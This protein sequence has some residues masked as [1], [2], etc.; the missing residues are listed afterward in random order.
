M[1]TVL[2]SVIPTAVI[3]QKLVV[4]TSIAYASFSALWWWEIKWFIFF[5]SRCK[6]EEAE[7]EKKEKQQQMRQFDWKATSELATNPS[8]PVS[9]RVDFSQFSRV[10][11]IDGNQVEMSKVTSTTISAAK[12][13]AERASLVCSCI[14]QGNSRG[15]PCYNPSCQHFIS[16]SNSFYSIQREASEQVP[17]HENG[18]GVLLP[19][20]SNVSFSSYSVYNQ[21]KE[22][23]GNSPHRSPKRIDCRDEN[24]EKDHDKGSLSAVERARQREIGTHPS[25]QQKMLN[26]EH[27]ETVK[28]GSKTTSD[29][30]LAFRS[31]HR[32]VPLQINL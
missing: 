18:A 26:G 31:P 4:L 13:G 29:V 2:M 14:R 32:Q 11:D 9:A 21:L 17:G 16:V 28:P 7:A 20:Q 1:Y 27:I 19:L 23:T 15:P 30:A 25:S 6:P 24:Q 8:V 12:N 10:S 3:C 5:F 22:E